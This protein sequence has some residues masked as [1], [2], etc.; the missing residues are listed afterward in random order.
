MMKISPHALIELLT[1][2]LADRWWKNQLE[3][4]DSRIHELE[5]K[6]SG[7]QLRPIMVIRRRKLDA[8]L[9]AWWVSISLILKSQFGIHQMILVLLFY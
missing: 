2:V 4:R 9:T 1:Q 8:I 5:K 7:F 6:I 3:T